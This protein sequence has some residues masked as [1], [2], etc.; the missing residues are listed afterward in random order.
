MIVGIDL[1]T[2]KS[3]VAVWNDGP[4]IISD[5]AGNRCIPSKVVVTEG[6][7]IAAG[8]LATQTPQ[9]YS[10]PSYTI[11]SVKRLMG[12]TGDTA[13]GVWR[14]YPQE[15]SAHILL[16]LR[17]HVEK[18]L[19]LS[20]DEAVLAVPA[21]FNENQRRA[22]YEAAEI[23]GIQVH[24]LLNESTAV[25]LAYAHKKK[26]TERVLVFDMGGGT[27]DI[28]VVETGNGVVQVLSADGDDSL[29]GDDV[30]EAA[31]DMIQE[32]TD[33]SFSF[34]SLDHF[35]QCVLRE[36]AENAKIELST[37]QESRVY[38][39]GFL[40]VGAN[41]IDLDVTLFRS[42]L[43]ERCSGL[44]R[45]ITELLL[46]TLRSAGLGPSNIDQCL[47]IGGATRMPMI[48]EVVSKTIG[49]PPSTGID[50]ETCVAEGAAIV[51]AVIDG[52]CRDIVLLDVASTSY[53]IRAKGGK[54]EPII[55]KNSALPSRVSRV[56]TT[57]T[58]YQEIVAFSLYQGESDNVLDNAYLGEIRVSNILPAR[59]GVPEIH[60]TFEIDANGMV[61]VSAKDVLRGFKQC[62]EIKGLF[63]LDEAQLKAMRERLSLVLQE[64]RVEASKEQGF[65][66]LQQLE[67]IIN[68]SAVYLDWNQLVGL[69]QLRKTLDSC[70]GEE[71]LPKEFPDVLRRSGKAIS[72]AEFNMANYRSSIQ[73]ALKIREAVDEF[74]EK[75]NVNDR[76]EIIV[77]RNGTELIGDY[78]ENGASS[79][80]L[81]KLVAGVSTTLASYQTQLLL[82]LV[83][84]I[85]ELPSGYIW[86]QGQTAGDISLA[87]RLLSELDI[88]GRIVE[89]LS[90]IST[91]AV[92]TGDQRRHL[93]MRDPAVRALVI[94]I[95]LYFGDGEDLPV[96]F[97]SAKDKGW[98]PLM[99]TSLYALE[100]FQPVMLRHRAISV[101]ENIFSYSDYPFNI[102]KE[103]LLEDDPVVK[104]VLFNL[105]NRQA[106]DTLWD[107]IKDDKESGRQLA[108]HQMIL[109]KLARSSQVDAQL[110]VIDVLF[111]IGYSKQNEHLIVKLLEWHKDS[112]IG[113]A[114]QWLSEFGSDSET[115]QR[116]LTELVKEGDDLL[117]PLY[118]TYCDRHC[119]HVDFDSLR[120]ILGSGLS[121]TSKERVLAFVAKSRTEALA[122][123]MEFFVKYPG[124]V[125]STASRY[126]NDLVSGETYEIRWLW[127]FM[128]R[129]IPYGSPMTCVD[130]ALL[131]LVQLRR[132]KMTGVL[133]L[134]KD[135]LGGDRQ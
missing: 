65:F 41:R 47:L 113:P 56:F 8:L 6:R 106:P 99:L 91:S 9:R 50:P 89:L 83:Q 128:Q 11:G 51:G 70:L 64:R 87:L 100:I 57:S 90:C 126:V 29:G 86:F 111:E 67:R 58:D 130:H 124:F 12:K 74:T 88:T 80:E 42:E 114:L 40:V 55:C 119:L 21:H 121:D 14:G 13:W 103:Y 15:V 37:R 34:D 63:G 23:A 94:A 125:R 133:K 120:R 97:P 82:G 79:Q 26:S 71:I 48:R 129:K 18:S 135:E 10:M 27:L 96:D 22:T 28:S 52:K 72:D 81:Q 43:E 123:L 109:D 46:R 5:S 118:L 85:I 54:F 7:R 39:P 105:L 32:R 66:R 127:R 69:R 19:G 4:Q 31:I 16:E 33:H 3:A 35:R 1:G 132:P 115:V 117:L 98:T 44:H 25:A 36:C 110:F 49:I 78:L 53:G 62:L 68:E 104:D 93:V 61:S 76:S 45:R 92:A 30:D 17:W 112:I 2:S 59:A 122:M 116:I 38:L 101:I 73:E 84:Q 107:M 108:K 134:I 24:R 60:V 95:N 131:S 102:A 75:Y 77:L 20:F